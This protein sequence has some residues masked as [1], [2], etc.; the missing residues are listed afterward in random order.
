MLKDYCGI[1]FS[2]DTAL[3]NKKDLDNIF[4]KI[5]SLN[6]RFDE[7]LKP[8]KLDDKIKY[9]FDDISQL[10]QHDNSMIFNV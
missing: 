7:N 9:E 10:K 4:N 8:Y 2:F 6:I 5:H 3:L 1:K